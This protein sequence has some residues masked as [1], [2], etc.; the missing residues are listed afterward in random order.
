MATT[1]QQAVGF[2]GNNEGGALKATMYWNSPNIGATN[3][4]GF[5]ALPAGFK[6]I[7]SFLSGQLVENGI[8]GIWWSTSEYDIDKAWARNLYYYN[9]NISRQASD[10]NVGVS[11]RCLKD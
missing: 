2:R 3:S 8:S 11:V 7:F 5:T 1:D 4:S 10:K 9:S 6:S